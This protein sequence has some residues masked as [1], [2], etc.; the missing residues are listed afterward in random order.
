MT[1]RTPTPARAAKFASAFA[2]GR[3]ELIRDAGHNV[4]EDQPVALAGVL[5]SLINLA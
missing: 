1:T 4:Q 5:R 3:W 2:N